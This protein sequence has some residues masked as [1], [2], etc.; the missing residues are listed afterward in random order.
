MSFYTSFA[1][2]GYGTA[3]ALY[4]EEILSH[5]DQGYKLRILTRSADKP[6]FKELKKHG[7]SIIRVDYSSE[8]SIRS[9][10]EGADIVLSA[11]R[12]DG[13]EIQDTVI[14]AAK[15]AGIKLYVPSE[16]GRDTIGF[17]E[18]CLFP[19]YSHSSQLK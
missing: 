10:L 4:A 6:A 3:G 11:L 14:R 18:K 15:A 5:N 8:D 19:Y 9:A 13:L 16:Y 7:V 17:T 2:I 1:I 12:D